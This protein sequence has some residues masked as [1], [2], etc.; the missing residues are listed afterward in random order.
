MYLTFEEIALT[1][2]AV[3][4]SVGCFIDQTAKDESIMKV[5]VVLILRVY[6]H[7]K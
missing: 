1:E 6:M 5:I 2:I 7:K 4:H 3:F